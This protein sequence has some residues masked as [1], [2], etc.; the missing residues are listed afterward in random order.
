MKIYET[1]WFS[2]HK[3]V[4]IVKVEFE[5]GNGIQYFIA[6]VKGLDELEDSKYIAEWGARFPTRVGDVLFA[7]AW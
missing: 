3:T 7:E 1:R 5:D 2:A 4:G 6:P